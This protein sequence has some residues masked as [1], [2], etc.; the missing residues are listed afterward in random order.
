MRQVQ[1][2]LNTLISIF[3]QNRKVPSTSLNSA[4]HC[5]QRQLH[6][7]YCDAEKPYITQF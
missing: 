5:E 2:T 3:G 4:V 6:D 1:H 7:Y